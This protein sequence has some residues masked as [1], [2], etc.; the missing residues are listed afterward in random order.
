MPLTFRRSDSAASCSALALLALS[1]GALHAQDAQPVFTLDPIIVQ[2]RDELGDEADRATSM[3]VSDRELERARTGD[4][5]DVFSGIASVSV[6]GALPLTQKIFVNGVDMLN[7][8]VTVDGTAQNNRAFHHVSANAI[9][10]G[11]LKQVRADATVSPADAGPYAL[12]GSVVFET[13]DATDILEPGDSFGGNVRLSF[14]DNGQTLQSSLTLAG[15]QGGFEWLLYGK[16][17]DGEDYEDGDGNRV[18]GTRAA[19]ES[20]LGKVAYEA[21]GHRFEFSAQRLMDSSLRQER[22][23]FGGFNG[24]DD[25]LT[26]YNTTRESYSFVYETPDAT[27]MWDP[28]VHIGYSESEIV[29]PEPWDSNG[30]S[31]TF[32]ATFQNTFHLSEGNTVTAGIDYQDRFGN[33]LSPTY[34]ED[35]TEES[36]NV[37]LFAQARLQPTD[38]LKV[39]FGARYDSQSFTGVNGFEGDFSGWSGNASLAFAATDELTLRG[40]VS[41]VFG[42]LVIEDNYEYWRMLGATA[43][44]GL[45]AARADNAT[46]GFDWTRG[47]LTLSGE[48]FVTEIKNARS[49]TN[50][51]DFKSKG[52]NLGATYGW[53]TGF[54]RMTLSHSDVEID[55]ASG[56]SFTAQDYGAPLGTLVAFEVEQETRVD[57][58]KV[59]GGLDVALDYDF[60][61]PA[62]N[63]FDG[64]TVVNAWAEY[65][66][67]SLPNLTI[68]AEVNN[69]FDEQYADRAT[70]GGEYGTIIPL[71]EPGRTISLV[72][73]AKF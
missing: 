35:Q 63:D 49:S 9:D 52:F 38:R 1:G 17:A 54:A 4:L 59:G 6:G 19:L 24:V 57:G 13:V 11:L 36:Q 25:A 42:G 34:A 21:G 50:N 23:N 45:E 26:L 61:D 33:Y 31:G 72:A 58:L 60:D 39:S 16:L 43:Y 32:S 67:P 3:Y 48:L 37:G 56:E 10:P 14:S 27:G 68:R 66:P 55:G 46:I 7:L 20:Y 8:G 62:L 28:R 29:K 70:Y 73:V 5:K 40:G 53:G 12:A 15:Q 30:R 65:V 41:S 69:L 22:A 64:Y 47:D 51:F 44:D 2:Q 71:R 18:Y